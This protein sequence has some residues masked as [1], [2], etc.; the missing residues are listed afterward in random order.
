V[1]IELIMTLQSSLINT[2]HLIVTLHTFLVYIHTKGLKMKHHILLDALSQYVKDIARYSPLPA[3]IEKILIEKAQ[4][5]DLYAR[6]KVIEANL[7]YVVSVAQT[8]KNKGAEIMDLI[9]VGNLA[10]IKAIL[11]FDKKKKTLFQHYAYF[12]IKKNIVIELL[13]SGSLIK[14]SPRIQNIARKIKKA[15][16][17]LY[18]R[19]GKEPTIKQ[20]SEEIGLSEDDIKKIIE[21]LNALPSTDIIGQ[22]YDETSFNAYDDL[23]NVEFDT[24]TSLFI[25]ERLQ[26]ALEEAIDNLS[27]QETI[28]LKS[29]H[30]LD[31]YPKKTFPKIASELGIDRE[32]VRVKY[33]NI[34]TKIAK[35]VLEENNTLRQIDDFL[36]SI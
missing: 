26:K 20:I 3:E 7:K 6:N 24:S 28:I 5:G 27:Q 29:Y 2:Y 35:K 23:L 36:G 10:L 17:L 16:E 33:R 32:Y 8:Y 9:S 31:D 21:E 22:E 25:R 15:R 14:V 11:R 1:L 12:Y 30:G 34:L 18:V 4:L 13:A 19:N